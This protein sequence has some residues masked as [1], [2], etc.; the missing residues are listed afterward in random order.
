MNSD[1]PSSLIERASCY[2]RLQRFDSA[3]ADANK[4]IRLQRKPNAKGLYVKGDALYNLGDF[5]HAL[6]FYNRAQRR[7]IIS[8]IV[9]SIEFC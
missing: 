7:Y 6:M 5:E 3:L 8:N 9:E 1:D 4:A 2:N